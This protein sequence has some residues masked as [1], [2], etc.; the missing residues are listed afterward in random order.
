MHSPASS[1]ST[2]DQNH[3]GLQDDNEFGIKCEDDA[4]NLGPLTESKLAAEAA[5]Q[6]YDF[7][8]SNPGCPH[9]RFPPGKPV[10]SSPE[11]KRW[12]ALAREQNLAIEYQPLNP[13]T[14]MS[15]LRYSAYKTASSVAEFLRFGTLCGYPAL[16]LMEDLEFDYLRGYVTFP[17]NT[18]LPEV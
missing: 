12:I 11:T 16:K 13:K 1:T 18:N 4:D 8:P 15:A 5:L 6:T 7:N 2:G 3:I 17:E 9:R 10:E 14:G